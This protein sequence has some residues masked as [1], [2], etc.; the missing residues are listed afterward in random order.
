MELGPTPFGEINV[1]PIEEPV[2]DTRVSFWRRFWTRL[3]GGPVIR[4][5][6]KR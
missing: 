3:F 1:V 2:E 6:G 4:D 5:D